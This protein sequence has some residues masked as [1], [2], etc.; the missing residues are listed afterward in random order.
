MVKRS[1]SRASA[2]LLGAALFLAASAPALGEGSSPASLP[3]EAATSLFS[4]DMG[5]K[6][7]ELLVHGSWEAS[8]MGQ[9]GL[10]LDNSGGLSLSDEVP[11]LFTQTPDLYLSFLLLKK[12]FVEARVTSD[13]SEVRYSAGYKGGEGELIK[14]I[15]VGND[16]ISFPALPF[17]S[18]GTGSYRSFGAAAKVGSETFE[19]RAMLRYD[20]A[21]RVEKKFVGSSEVTET[22][23][24]ASDFIRGRYFATPGVPATNLEVYV[25]STSGTIS[26]GD[27]NKYRLLASSEYSY[28][29]ATGFIA[30]SLAATSRVIAYYAGSG[31]ASSSVTL[32]SGK[33]C[34]LL[35][36]P[37]LR[38]AA[39]ARDTE[40]LCR[41]AMTGG[42][43][44]KAF[45]RDLSSGLKDSNYEVRVD[46]S[47]YAEV[48]RGSVTDPTN[49]IYRRPFDGDMSY[50]YTTDFTS[51]SGDKTYSPNLSKAIV[52]RRYLPVSQI[53]IDTD[54]I[55]GSVEVTRN[56]VSDYAFTVDAKGGV[57]TLATEPGLDEEIVVTYL[58]ESSERSSGSIAAGLGGVFD[59]GDKRSAW[60]ALGLRW[61]VP[62]TSY[63]SAGVS[64]PGTLTL[65]AGEKDAEGAFQQNAAIAGTWKTDEAAGRY[66]VEGME[67]Q[68]SYATSFRLLTATTDYTITQ[69]VETGLASAFPTLESSLH[70][71]GTS[72]RALKIAAD[73]TITTTAIDLVETLSDAPTIS[74]FKT[75]AFFA[76]RSG[77]GSASLTVTIDTGNSSSRALSVTVP[78]TVLSTSW[79][80]YIFK[81]GS[82]ESIL[83]KQNVEDADLETVGSSVY[84]DSKVSDAARLT[85]SLT[86]AL[87]D[88]VV[89]VDEVCLEDSTGQAS[90]LFSG[91]ASYKNADFSLGTSRLTLLKGIEAS[92][93]SSMGL[94]ESSYASGGL[95]AATSL[96]PLK[97]SANMRGSASSS[98]AS[99]RGGHS[100][101]LPAST[102]PLSFADSFDM[103]TQAGSFGRED[104]LALAGDRAFS[105]ALDSTT[106]WYPSSDEGLLDQAWSGS[107]SLA[108]GRLALALS[109][110][111]SAEPAFLDALGSGYFDSWIGGFA[112]LLPAAEDSSDRRE[113]TASLTGAL[114]PGK[115]ILS[116]KASVVG[117]P[118]D[119]TPLRDESLTA[120]LS[121]PLSIGKG[122]LLSPYYQRYWLERRLAQG[123]AGTGLVD[124]ASLSLSDLS[125]SASPL[126]SSVP[127]VEFSDSSVYEAFSSYTAGLSDLSTATY[128]PS[129]GLLVSRSY[130]SSW[131]DLVLPS[132]LSAAYKRSLLR[133][134]DDSLS[135]A[136]GLEMKASFGAINLF[137]SMGAYPLLPG[138]ESD[139]YSSTIQGTVSL[140]SGES[141]FRSDL[142]LQ[143]S[144]TLYGNGNRDSFTLDQRFSLTTLPSSTAW[145]E[146]LSLGLSLLRARSWLLD[147]YRLALRGVALPSP[148][149]DPTS[150]VP[151]GK[152]TIV[153]SFL[154][155]LAGATPVSRTIFSLSA[156]L[157]STESDAEAQALGFDIAENLEWK[158][159]VPE[160]LTVSVKPSLVQK[161]DAD[162]GDLT[163]GGALTIAATVS[164]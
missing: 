27:G 117:E 101:S 91:G 133:S 142:I 6:D 134:S 122:F 76:R 70:S 32:G 68:G 102:F 121:L 156:A 103:N 139:E 141:E 77:I 105:L 87:A 21:D 17:L 97:V 158:I 48:T 49:A 19:G 104:R 118:Q 8:L 164:F 47:G 11:I 24:A 111:N 66:R 22:V 1:L 109:A 98:A 12:Y 89:W 57:L 50:L 75:F 78:S 137:G 152:A 124:V 119:A 112:Y 45:V 52:V 63:A 43:G 162:S 146:S 127:F 161:R 55:E 80:R 65:T 16:G 79:Q 84:Y 106:T 30:L 26:G 154:S 4:V 160:R 96:G 5:G 39:A 136:N 123:A 2:L 74:D 13:A 92:A 28:K 108:D 149:P 60:A 35:Y 131:Y 29:A 72:Q 144:A 83:Y 95:S 157:D 61:S 128:A 56:G 53:S 37:A 147:L 3:V 73:S 25:Q 36:D 62:G 69:P 138:V 67:N 54:V 155:E 130:G 82:T 94:S 85:I 116:L 42:E 99:L 44:V 18:L 9:T 34:A 38:P 31:S 10:V 143:N 86:G 113:V 107:L 93:N 81:Y 115:N 40:I 145:S 132:A 135:D 153:S 129:L 71:D 120:R 58:R 151:A 114:S 148:V 163:M 125:A 140:V 14:E 126:L 90:L 33:V 150:P 88:E 46:S 15:R 59:L 110:L 51:D 100:I 159:T 41:Y 7:A 64:N 20:Q 23:V